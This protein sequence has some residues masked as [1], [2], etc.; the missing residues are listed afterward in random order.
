MPGLY[1]TGFASMANTDSRQDQYI[2]PLSN[3]YV[4]VTDAS[5]KGSY[6]ISSSENSSYLLRGTVNYNKILMKKGLCSR[7]T[8]EE[9]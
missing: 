8:W 5:K 4:G 2:S 9:R 6:A 7:Q 3:T 1:V